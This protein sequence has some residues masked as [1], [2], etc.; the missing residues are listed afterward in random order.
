MGASLTGRMDWQ[1][2]II[3]GRAV[4]RVL[5]QRRGAHSTHM[6]EHDANRVSFD[7]TGRL[8]VQTGPLRRTV[9][10]YGPNDVARW[11]LIRAND[12]EGAT[13]MIESKV[14]IWR[15]RAA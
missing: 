12:A 1:P 9:A 2:G 14:T 6:V 4:C 3:T 7:A 13:R 10:R 5:I 11:A 15:S 8:Y